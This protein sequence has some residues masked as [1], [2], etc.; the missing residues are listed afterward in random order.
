ME[1]RGT[2]PWKVCNGE[3][4]RLNSASKMAFKS[5]EEPHHKYQSAPT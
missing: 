2:P 1:P 5:T 4:A 3:Q